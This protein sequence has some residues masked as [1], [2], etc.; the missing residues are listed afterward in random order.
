MGIKQKSWLIAI[1]LLI[2]PIV[3]A[4][5]W[6]GTGDDTGL[7]LHIA[8][9]GDGQ[10]RSG[11]ANH[12]KFYG[13]ASI[14]SGVKGRA[15]D[16]PGGEAYLDCGETNSLNP[17][18]NNVTYT[19]WF[20]T[21]TGG[22]IL[23]FQG[24]NG[25]DS[26]GVYDIAINGT[27]QLISHFTRQVSGT[28]FYAGAESNEFVADGEW[29][30]AAAVLNFSEIDPASELYLD[31]R[32]VATDTTTNFSAPAAQTIQNFSIGIKHYNTGDLNQYAGSI[33]EVRI[34][35]RSLTASEISNLYNSSKSYH[36]ELWTT[37]R[38]GL[39]TDDVIKMI[40]KRV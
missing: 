9:E 17:G 18:S 20:K 4:P 3:T 36:M 33:D 14:T 39:T 5:Y 11:Q 19:A 31:G 8:C 40:L 1:I 23:N 13:A 27:G 37:P 15:C 25:W 2:I 10:D 16:F 12:C 30:F 22:M 35:N 32:L 6:Y 28:Y 7:V 24:G 29:H 38:K 34:Y 26:Q 21:T